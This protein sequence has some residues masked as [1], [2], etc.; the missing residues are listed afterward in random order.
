MGK[1]IVFSWYNNRGRKDFTNVRETLGLD[2]LISMRIVYD[3]IDP[4]TNAEKYTFLKRSHEI[5]TRLAKNNQIYVLEQN[6]LFF[7]V[8][9]NLDKLVVFLN[10]FRTARRQ[11]SK[12]IVTIKKQEFP[13]SVS[14]KLWLLIQRGIARIINEI[15]PDIY[16]FNAPLNQI[17]ILDKLS[18]PIVYDMKDY[19]PELCPTSLKGLAIDAERK[20]L[21]E[22]D[23]VIVASKTLIP[24]AKEYAKKVVW[25]PNGVDLKS[26]Y[27]AKPHKGFDKP[28][29]GYAGGFGKS[30]RVDNRLLIETAMMMPDI[31]FVLVGTGSLDEPD[32]PENV[33]VRGKLAKKELFNFL[34][35]IDVG[36]IP[37][38]KTR[39]SHY[40]CPLKLFEY[41]SQGKPIISTRLKE[42][43]ELAGAHVYF[44]DTPEEMKEK[45]EKALREGNKKIDEWVRQFDW[46]ILA[47]KYENAL[48]SVINAD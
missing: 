44:A 23:L 22:S 40:S 5:Y 34:S 25:I 24:H 30:Y 3:S 11:F 8:E 9:G 42:I 6:P 21:R 7:D 39:F 28:I 2:G 38:K 13:R 14:K 31:Y 33:I 16:V 15:D 35:S 41:A 45:I 17:G 29:V 10:R 26:G 48:E 12:N 19:M 32:L 36:I 37:Y 1:F 4:W 27:D 18:C 47:E 43:E 46:D 20:A